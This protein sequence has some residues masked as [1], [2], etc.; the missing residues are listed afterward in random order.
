MNTRKHPQQV[1]TPRAN[2]RIRIALGTRVRLAA[3]RAFWFAVWFV[4]RAYACT[5]PMRSA[6]SPDGR[7]KIWDRWFLTSRPRG[8]STGTP[9][10]YLHHLT[11]ADYDERE[12]NHPW[13]ES[14]T[15]V[16]RGFYLETR[17][18]VPFA[19]CTGTKSTFDA[20]TY[21]RI[22]QV[23]GDTWTLFYAGP[24]HGRGWGFRGGPRC[25]VCGRMMSRDPAGVVRCSRC[26]A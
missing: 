22:I 6:H 9:G 13:T 21:H 15:R 24:K 2:I 1:E 17:D 26:G 5:R 25:D 12:H 7:T 23:R 18:G 14:S 10:W 16:L 3:E 20:S 4:V 8:D 19:R 11:A